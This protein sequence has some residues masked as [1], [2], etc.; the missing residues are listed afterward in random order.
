MAGSPRE[1]PYLFFDKTSLADLRARAQAEPF[2]S[3]AARLRAHAEKCMAIPMPAQARH[4]EAVKAFLSDGSYNPAYLRNS[5]DDFYKQSYLV[6]EV[7]PT[8]AFAYQLTGDPRYGEAGKEWLLNFASR[9]EL[10]RKQRSADFDAANMMFA[11]SLGYDWLAELLDEPQRQ[12]VRSALVHMA[13]PMMASANGFL[14]NQ[15][16]DLIRGSLG[17]NHTTRTHGLFGLTP[18]VLLYE[19]PEARD[20]LD[21]EIQ[22]QRDRLLPSA[23]A[24]DGEYIDA[25][26]HFES[27]LEDST[28]FLEALRRMGGENLFVDPMLRN[29]FAGIPR[30][31]LY[32]LE[33]RL[34]GASGLYSWLAL[35]GALKDPV[36][37]W[38]ALRD[39]KLSKVD[40]IFGYL[41]YDPSVAA[42]PPVD[43]PGSVYWPYSGMVKMC[44][45]WDPGHGILVPFRCGPEIGKDLGDQNGFRLHMN[46]EW[47]L[48]RLPDAHKLAAQPAEFSWDLYAW[49]RG[50]PAENVLIPDPDD[51]GDYSS[52]RH[53][54]KVLLKGG[55]Q[56]AQYPPMKGREF[57]RQWLSRQE[58]PKRGELRVVHLGDALDYVCG[59]AH[60]AYYS[61]QPRLWVRHILF[62]KEGGNGL[63]PYIL[64]CDEAEAD[65]DPQTFAWQIHPHFPIKPEPGGIDVDGRASSLDVRFLLPADGVMIEKQTPAP[66]EKERTDFIQWQTVGP[67][68]SCSFLTAL[69]PRARPEAQP[70]PGFRVV[71]ASGGWAVEVKSAHGTDLALFRSEHAD[72]VNAEGT[73]TTGTAALLRSTD[74]GPATLYEMGKN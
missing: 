33:R 51:D 29:R 18:L 27:A 36:A 40:E 34:T 49:F 46:G 47:L 2:L 23:W 31:W 13:G 3:L 32:G 37:Q 16:P 6:K 10:S 30:Y 9:P 70:P 38:T 5:Y 55:I 41:F 39:S 56:F 14:S 54:G 25:W 72:S 69:L 67:Q 65:G 45:D 57:N 12:L 74:S 26:D 63:A 21:A 7:I 8:L 73:S 61:V 19:V 48:Q 15:E 50:S 24:P 43:P 11:L 20:W 64:V 52:Y 42:A 68:Q 66:I 35:A 71:S 60:R 53:T 62:V 4:I 44:T 58:M 17:N 59:E 28:P 22:L 1:H